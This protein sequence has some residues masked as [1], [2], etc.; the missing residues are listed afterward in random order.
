MAGDGAGAN[1]TGT[2]IREVMVV[3]ASHASMMAKSDRSLSDIKQSAG[4]IEIGSTRTS[5][6]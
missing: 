5:P 3:L 2:S 1:T 4:A 6:M